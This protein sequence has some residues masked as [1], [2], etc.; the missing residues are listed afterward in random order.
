MQY[1]QTKVRYRSYQ[2]VQDFH[3]QY[4]YIYVCEILSTQIAPSL[5]CKNFNFNGGSEQLKLL[6]AMT[7]YD[8]RL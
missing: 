7:S 3:N 1:Q 6:S 4:I 5:R 2:L 8:I